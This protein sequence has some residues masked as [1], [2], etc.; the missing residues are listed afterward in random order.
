MWIRAKQRIG[1]KDDVVFKDI[2]APGATDAARRGENRKHIQDR[3]AHMSGETTEI[4]IEE[5]F[6]DVSNI[7]MDLPWR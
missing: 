5:V 4:Y 3:L 7:D 1:M 6:P 2:R